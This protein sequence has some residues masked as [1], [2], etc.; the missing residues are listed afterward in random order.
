MHENR[1]TSEAPAAKPGGRA[2]GEGE[3]HTARVYVSEESHSGVVPMS[4]SNKD[5]RS[6]AEN[7]E[8]RP[9][10]K[11]N[12]RQPNTHPTQSGKGDFPIVIS[13]DRM[14]FKRSC[15]RDFRVH[16]RPTDGSPA[17]RWVLE[18]CRFQSDGKLA[19]YRLESQ[20]S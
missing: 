14:I 4:H 8:G 5:R 7:E 9:L 17:I 1:E 20:R 2:A 12:A 13:V 16:C 10:V 15:Y 11:E 19:V 18:R 3:S 6:F